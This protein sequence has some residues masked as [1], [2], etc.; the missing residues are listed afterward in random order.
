MDKQFSILLADLRNHFRAGLHS[1]FVDELLSVHVQEAPSLASF[2]TQLATHP[3]DLI[4]V[5]QSL[6][7]GISHLLAGNTVILAHE[8]DKALFLT[9]REHEARAY[10]NDD[11]S[12][13][14]LREV[15]Q[16]KPGEFLIDPLF[17]CWVMDQVGE[18]GKGQISLER[19]TP[20]E[21]EVAGLHNKGLSY[22]E[23]AKQL[24]MSKE[25]AKRHMA[26]IRSKMKR[27]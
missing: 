9:A 26:T 21:R 19:L 13:H 10:L 15:L 25:T 20:K 14:L 27:A 8:P 11:P 7:V 2:E 22:V 17:S 23:I 12:E 3:F 16:L 4:V 1:F 6:L 18:N 5:N 24:C